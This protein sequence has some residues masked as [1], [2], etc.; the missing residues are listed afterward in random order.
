MGGRGYGCRGARGAALGV[1]AVP[2]REFEDAAGMRALL[3]TATA[4]GAGIAQL[5]N[6]QM[7]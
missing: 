4:V 2:V 7:R 1:R 5:P 3:G 6:W